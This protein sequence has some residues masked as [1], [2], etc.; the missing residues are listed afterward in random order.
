MRK[1]RAVALAGF[2]LAA[3]ASLI[4]GHG[5]AHAQSGVPSTSSIG[6]ET[7]L[8]VP[9]FVSLKADVVNVRRGPG[10]DYPIDWVFRRVGLPVEII[11]E[12]DVWRQIRDSDGAT[13]WVHTRMLSGRRTALVLPWARAGEGQTGETVAIRDDQG[14]SAKVIARLTA[15]SLVSVPRCTGRTCQISIDDYRGWVEQPKLW[16]VYAGES[17]D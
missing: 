12:A 10:Q 17:F 1:A 15:G 16:G 3:L 5:A 6:R 7:G 13:G 2:A 4:G 14:A 11:D 8:A 9:R